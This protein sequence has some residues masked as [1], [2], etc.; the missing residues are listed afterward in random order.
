MPEGFKFSREHE[1]AHDQ[2]DG[3][4]LIGISHYAQ[5]AMGDIVFV[6]LP[7]VGDALEA[8]LEF[9]V[10]E[11]VKTVSD[12]YAPVSGEVV[13]INDEL[14]DS[15]ELVNQSP[16]EGGWVVRIKMSNPE[17]LDALMDAEEYVDYLKESE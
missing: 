16:Y 4:A 1:W 15:P 6:E 13:E 9:G 5:D 2:G 3:T 14:E 8:E 10:V 17:E 12:L 11:S 7:N